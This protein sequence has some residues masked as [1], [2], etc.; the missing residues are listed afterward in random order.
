MYSSL[1]RVLHVP[2]RT[3]YGHIVHIVNFPWY[4]RIDS[5]CFTCIKFNVAEDAACTQFNHRTCT[6]SRE[7]AINL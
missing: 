2:L 1:N 5:C 4:K 6:S 7:N 3:L